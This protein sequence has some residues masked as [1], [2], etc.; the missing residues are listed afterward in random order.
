MP[1]TVSFW[2]HLHRGSRH[3][4]C[5]HRL[6]ENQPSES[7]LALLARP[8]CCQWHS[9]ETLVRQDASPALLHRQFSVALVVFAMLLIDPPQ[10]K[11]F[12][13]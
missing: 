1:A 12:F 3:R 6:P 11:G 5:D 13:P 9:F 8:M 10:Y 2:F 4:P 7:A